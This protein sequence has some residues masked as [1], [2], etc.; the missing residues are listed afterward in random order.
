MSPVQAAEIFELLINREKPLE[1]SEPGD[2]K[3]P[4]YLEHVISCVL[5]FFD[6]KWEISEP[7][8]GFYCLKIEDSWL[9]YLDVGPNSFMWC[10]EGHHDSVN[11]DEVFRY[12][13][14]TR[15]SQD[16]LISSDRC[17]TFRS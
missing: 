6:L 16:I 8:N 13:M 3:W 2:R 14:K 17:V 11:T 4:D 15:K 9:R 5:N 12:L 7:V 10:L 1:F